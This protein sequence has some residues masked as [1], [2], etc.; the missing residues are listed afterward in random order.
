[1]SSEL[2]PHPI[3]ILLIG[4]ERYY[5]SNQTIT[6]Y[7]SNDPRF[8]LVDTVLTAREGITTAQRIKP[9][10]ILLHGSVE[11]MYDLDATERLLEVVPNA[12]VVLILTTFENQCLIDALTV[13][14]ANF[15][16]NPIMETE[17]EEVILAVTAKGF[18][19]PRDE[20]QLRKPSSE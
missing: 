12:K 15:L 16:G 19:L 5:N 14:V 8:Q 17:L 10:L 9:D 1:M 20:F 7:L 3:R 18:V 4:S 6:T 2:A 11:D 13:G